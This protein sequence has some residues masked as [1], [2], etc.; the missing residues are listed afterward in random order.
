[1]PQNETARENNLLKNYMGTY[2]LFGLEILIAAD[3]IETI[4]NP[5]MEEIVFLAAVVVIRTVISY[6]LGK[7][8][9]N[10]KIS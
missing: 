4:M 2:I 9:E 8:M 1:M 6:F 3:I 5:T 10:T 7:E